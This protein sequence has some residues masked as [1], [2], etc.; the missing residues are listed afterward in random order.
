MQCSAGPACERE[1]GS[2]LRRRRG[3]VPPDCAR[4]A[5]KWDRPGGRGGFLPSALG[6]CENIAFAALGGGAVL[7]GAVCAFSSRWKVYS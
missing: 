2:A 6:T 4:D 5:V 1:A 7:T 3:G